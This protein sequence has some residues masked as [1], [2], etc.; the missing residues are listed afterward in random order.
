MLWWFEWIDQGDRYGVYRALARFAAGEDLRG[1]E[2]ACVAPTLVAYGQDL[3]C[4]AWRKGTHWLGYVV[5]PVWSVTG[6]DGRP[7]SGGVLTLEDAVP[8]CDLAVE[9]WDADSGLIVGTAQVAHGG[10]RPSF[11][12]PTFKRHLAFKVRQ[13]PVVG[14]R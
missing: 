12:V 7:W 13:V 6:G 2:A 9:W 8:A 3:W 14:S 11:A 1:R 10:D 4:R 5:D